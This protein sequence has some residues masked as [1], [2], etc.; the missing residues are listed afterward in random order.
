M[1]IVADE[2]IPFVKEVFGRLGEV[3]CLSGRAITTDTLA[4]AEVLLVRSI[5]RVDADLLGKTNLRYVGT[6]TIGTDHIDKACLQERGIRFANAAGSNANSVVQYVLTA[7]LVLSEKKG[8]TLQDKKL[9]IIGVGHIGS[10]LET[11]CQALGLTPL[12]HDP[13]RQRESGDAK[14]VDLSEVLQADFIT[15]HVPLTRTGPEPTWHL[16]SEETL[17]LLK[18]HQVLINTSRGAVVD[19]QTLKI[20]LQT[21]SPGAAVLDVWE[22]E[23]DIDL[24]LLAQVALGTPHIAGYSLDGKVNGTVMLYEALS[25][26]LNEECKISAGDLLPDPPLPMIELETSGLT[27]QSVTNQVMTRC[28]NIEA[29]DTALRRVLHEPEGKRGAFFD[30]LRKNYPVR[31]EMHNTQVILRSPHTELAAKLR[32]I[33]FDCF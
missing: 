7:L 30:Q 6:A 15:L 2:N 32:L 23:P 9:G 29:D 4:D 33:G 19:N 31:R 5:T 24:E 14:F 13:P 11:K 20:S 16:L 10:I 1:K 3:H 25:H 17:R 26:F 22:D 28:Y 18:P 21:G 27:P 8:W 12:L